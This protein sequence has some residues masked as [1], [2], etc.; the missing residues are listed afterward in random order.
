MRMKYAVALIKGSDETILGIF[1]T[2]GEADEFGRSN[3]IPREAGLHYCYAAT[4]SGNR[5]VGSNI[6]IYDYYNAV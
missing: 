4:F 2:K 1:K 6:K 5:Q 3:R